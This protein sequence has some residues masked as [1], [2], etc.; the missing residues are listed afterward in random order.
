MGAEPAG[1]PFALAEVRETTG[2]R[3]GVPDRHLVAMPQI[4]VPA[5]SGATRCSL[6]A[7]PEPE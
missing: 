2:N 4:D 7:C 6:F 5:R 1:H 3:A